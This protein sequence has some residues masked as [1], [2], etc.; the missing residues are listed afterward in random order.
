[1][2]LFW[3]VYV[4]SNERLCTYFYVDEDRFTDAACMLKL[5]VINPSYFKKL[6]GW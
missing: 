1:M 2:Q 3:S 5:Q 4:A 6:Y